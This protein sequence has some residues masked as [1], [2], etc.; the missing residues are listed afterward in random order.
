MLDTIH[1]ATNFQIALAALRQA[2]DQEQAVA[3]L[4]AQ[5]TQQSNTSVAAASA[6]SAS[7]LGATVN[8]VI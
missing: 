7:G 5:A 1:L 3:A 2:V 8:I 6:A 4:V